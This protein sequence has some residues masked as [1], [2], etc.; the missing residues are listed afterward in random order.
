MMNRLFSTRLGALAV[1][2]LLALAAI[3]LVL[4]YANSYKDGGNSSSGGVTVLV[5]TQT[6]TQ[7]TP[8]DQI[9]EGKFF[10]ESSVPQSAVVDGA[11]SSSDQLKGLVARSDIYPGE[12]L[13]LN[14]FQ[15]SQTTS[16]AVNLSP[17]QRAVSFPVEAGSGLVDQVQRGDRV[18]VVGT[19]DVVP[20]G[21]NG[22]PITG[23]QPIPMTRTVVSNALVL[24]PPASTDPSN[25]NGPNDPVMTLA[26]NNDDVQSVLFAQEKGSIWFVLRPAGQSADIPPSVTDV[27]AVLRG[28]S[29]ARGPVLRLTGVK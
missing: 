24:E 25:T 26:I 5:A 9:V 20:V 3:V 18:D 27:D 4:F 7:F 15:K 11:V 28:V 22:L 21:A 14:Q 23:A 17:G 19:F 16:V 2:S 29:S 1:A 10:R 12:Q 6:I 13:S 8:G